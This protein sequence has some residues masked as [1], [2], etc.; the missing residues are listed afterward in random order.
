MVKTM[1]SP[2][3]PELPTWQWYFLFSKLIQNFGW[4]AEELLDDLR[5]FIHVPLH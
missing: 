2:C 1:I 4:G 5:I 3:F